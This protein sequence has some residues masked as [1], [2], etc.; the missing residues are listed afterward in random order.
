MP[1]AVIRPALAVELETV[2]LRPDNSPEWTANTATLWNHV[3]Q[4]ENR[5]DARL[6]REFILALPK[7]LSAR[8]N[9]QLTVE[10]A[11]A[12]LVSK[13]MVVEVSL[14]NPKNGNNPH[15]HIQCTLRTIEGDKFSAK[16]PRE[17]ND[18]TVLLTQRESWGEAVNA[19]LEKA[20]RPERVDHRSL[21]D[22]GIDRIPEPKIGK[23]AVGM[24]ER[25]VVEDPRRFQLV[26]WVKSLNF[27]RPWLKAISKAGE[28]YQ[29]GMGAT[30]WE[31]SLNSVAEAGKTMGAAVRE[32]VMDTWAKMLQSRQ[33]AS[34][35]DIPPSGRNR[36]MD[37][38]R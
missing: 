16:K 26:R 10:W 29:H 21:K 23:E 31:R 13:G 27:A 25:G 15:A 14:H 18:K 32:T 3:E 38:E 20:G 1:V 33:S 9:F 35:H 5:K 6:A 7:E 11:Q 30:W 28:V 24:K 19:A 2:I 34:S 17:W 4:S 36:D 8:E 37:M 12:E 22:Q